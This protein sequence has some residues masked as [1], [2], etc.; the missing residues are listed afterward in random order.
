MVGLQVIAKG[1]G[2]MQGTVEGRGHSGGFRVERAL[3]EATIVGPHNVLCV[4]SPTEGAPRAPIKS[5]SMNED[6][7]RKQWCR[8]RPVVVYSLLY[9]ALQ[10]RGPNCCGH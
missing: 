10:A 1:E 5:T 6:A 3:P 8:L 4:N 2:A 7:K 9:G